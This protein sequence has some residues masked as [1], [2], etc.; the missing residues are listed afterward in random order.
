[1]DALKLV[2]VGSASG[3]EPDWCGVGEYK[4]DDSFEGEEYGLLVLAQGCAC[5]GFKDL[6]AA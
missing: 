4:F 2:D 1:M 6:E 3:W 5:E